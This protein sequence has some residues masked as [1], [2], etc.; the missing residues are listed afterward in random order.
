[1]ITEAE[2]AGIFSAELPNL[3]AD[4]GFLQLCVLFFS[5]Q[6][7]ISF[8]F[9]FR[10]RLHVR[11]ARFAAPLSPTIMDS[12]TVGRF[13]PHQLDRCAGTLQSAT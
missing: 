10:W 7:L 4:T 6:V 11:S 5:T 8:G 2:S 9:L 1:V 13:G 3:V 12:C